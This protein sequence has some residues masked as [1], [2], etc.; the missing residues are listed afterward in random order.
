MTH[1]KKDGASVQQLIEERGQIGQ[2]LER[3]ATATD[4][5]ENVR[6]KVRTGYE[7]RLGEI[8]GLL[9]GARKEIEDTLKRQRS[10]LEE[11]QHQEHD[12]GEKLAEAEVRH[13]V[14]ELDDGAWKKIS[15]EV[16]SLLEK[17]QE[18]LATA[19]EAADRTSAALASLDPNATVAATKGVAAVATPVHDGPVPLRSR[20]SEFVPDP[21]PVVPTLPSEKPK[22]QPQAAAAEPAPPAVAPMPEPPPKPKQ[23]DAFDE[24]A[25]IKSVTEDDKAGPA[26]H[27]ASGMAR[28]SSSEPVVPDQK[29]IDAG[30][31]PPVPRVSRPAPQ[32]QPQPQ[33]AAPAPAPSAPPTLGATGPKT[34][35]CKECGTMN[36]P[37]EWYCERCGAELS[38]V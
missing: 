19:K 17:V 26:A 27:R 15:T 38:A 28:L 3:L 21:D 12:A 5:P 6:S 30:G 8:A 13:S 20:V 32:P 9:Q 33:P 29:V 2:W 36:A 1:H 31:V 11:L 37:T 4:K 34:M 7:K 25:F 18:K 35:K 24:L 10:A 16:Q 14:G 22:P 23:T